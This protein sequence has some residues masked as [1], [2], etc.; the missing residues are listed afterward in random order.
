MFRTHSQLVRSCFTGMCLC[1]SCFSNSLASVDICQQPTIYSHLAIVF[2]NHEK[3]AADALN[4]DDMDAYSLEFA[5]WR[6]N[7]RMPNTEPVV[8]LNLESRGDAGDGGEDGRGA[9]H[10]GGVEATSAVMP[11]FAE[12]AAT[13]I[14]GLLVA[15]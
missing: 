13:L 9:G 5:E 1:L 2:Y 7:I 4:V 3:Y 11:S 6:F 10:R 8:R 12:H 15:K 14:S